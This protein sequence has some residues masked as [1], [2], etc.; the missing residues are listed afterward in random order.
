MMASTFPVREQPCGF[1]HGRRG[2]WSRRRA[3]RRARRVAPQRQTTTGFSTAGRDRM[4]VY[5][6]MAS[7]VP[8]AGFGSARARPRPRQI[9]V[10]QPARG[11]RKARR[12]SHTALPKGSIAFAGRPLK[13]AKRRGQHSVACPGDSDRSIGIAR[14]QMPTA[15]RS[16]DGA[17]TRP[18]VR[19][20]AVSGSTYVPNRRSQ[21]V[22]HDPRLTQWCSGALLWWTW[23]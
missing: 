3:T 10:P 1:V 4:K 5:I 17:S 13:G 8:T 16:G 20:P 11:G 19:S 18:N 22:K 23:W 9:G 6:A 12:T 2:A 21:T 15:T 14:G 7:R